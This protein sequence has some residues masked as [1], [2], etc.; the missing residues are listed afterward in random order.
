MCVRVCPAKAIEIVLSKD[1]PPA[2]VQVEGQP[3]VA[4]KKKF[5]CI[6]H[7]DRCVFCWQCAET[8]PKKALITTQ[9][10]ELAHVDRKEL[11]RRYKK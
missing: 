6:M 4:A 8:C 7:L 5:D 2:P 3:P 11:V 9:D 1:Q 10:F